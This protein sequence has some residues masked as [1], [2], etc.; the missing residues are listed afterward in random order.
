MVMWLTSHVSRLV[1]I[2]PHLFPFSQKMYSFD[3]IKAHDIVPVRCSL[4]RIRLYFWHGIS[5]KT[6]NEIIF[7]KKTL[8]SSWHIIA[9]I[10]RNSPPN[11]TELLFP[12][13]EEHSAKYKAFNNPY[14]KKW[15]RE[16]Q[17]LHVA[18]SLLCGDIILQHLMTSFCNI[19]WHHFEWLAHFGFWINR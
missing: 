16:T 12:V 13:I 1:K 7:E 11:N 8:K 15:R 18:G 5:P 4:Y 17:F 10:F 6:S 19:W 2:G 9:V 14:H 3:S